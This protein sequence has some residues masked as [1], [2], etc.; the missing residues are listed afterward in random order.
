[1]I[2]DSDVT[3][4]QGYRVSQ[5]RLTP[6]DYPITTLLE[7]MNTITEEHKIK[8]CYFMLEKVMEYIWKRVHIIFS[9]TYIPISVLFILD[10]K[11]YFR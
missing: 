1:M 3:S 9:W 5:I 7:Y 6:A 2:D 10:V 11:K 8:F 4:F